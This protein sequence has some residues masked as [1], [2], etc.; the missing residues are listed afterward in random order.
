MEADQD[1]SAQT[2][3][4]LLA[5]HRAMSRLYLSLQLEESFDARQY[6]IDGNGAVGWWEFVRVWN[7][8]KIAVQ[9]SWLE[10]IYLT[11]E[12]PS[13]SVVSRMVTMVLVTVILLSSCCFIFSTIP[14]LQQEDENDPDG[15]P[16]ANAVLT[17]IEAVCVVIFTLEYLLRL[18]TAS[19]MRQELTDK[20]ILLNRICDDN[21]IEWQTSKKRLL[22]FII[23]PSNVVDL[24]SILP[25][26]LSL[27]GGSD[28]GGSMVV[29][30][31]VRMM[32]VTRAVKIGRYIE[33]LTIIKITMQKSARAMY[34]LAFLLFGGIV[35]F[36]SLMYFAESGTWDPET[37]TYQRQEGVVWDANVRA[38]IDVLGE[39]PYRS[40]PASFWWALVTATTVGYGDHYPT[41]PAGKFVGALCMFWS[42][43]VLALPVGIIGSNFTRVWEE[44]EKEKALEIEVKGKQQKIIEQSAKA[45][46]PLMYARQIQIEVWHCEQFSSTQ[47]KIVNNCFLGEMQ[48]DMQLKD[49]PEHC[50]VT[51][52]LQANSVKG[53]AQASGRVTV[54]C[55]WQPQELDE[56]DKKD[57]L[58]KDAPLRGTLE[59]KVVR[60]DGLMNLDWKA[61]GMTDPFARV[62]VFPTSPLPDPKGNF[63]LQPQVWDTRVV[64]DS[65]SPLWDEKKLF[66]F[67][68][69]K[70]GVDA[71][72]DV[73]TQ[74]V[75]ESSILLSRMENPNSVSGT[76][77]TV[78]G[79]GSDLQ[80]S[81]ENA[82]VLS[83]LALLPQIAAELTLLRKKVDSM[84]QAQRSLAPVSP[85]LGAPPVLPE[86]TITAKQS[87]GNSKMAGKYT[88]P[89]MDT[90][91]NIMPGVPRDEPEEIA[92]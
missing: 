22:N 80:G 61:G 18:A 24:L 66:S 38:F 2:D 68:W 52:T 15:E 56:R 44:F 23:S 53:S 11:L 55:S 46:D 70:E 48:L 3:I 69:T 12:D 30:R 60:A 10:R 84:E 81:A 34:V 90:F 86:L 5:F 13:S 9:L 28:S 36:G 82:N 78:E 41:T 43:C 91:T 87:N 63:H 20:D 29:L 74:E 27:F 72:L 75:K 85:P 49:V 88:D 31:L 19:A 77:T 17:S 16:Q 64:E 54:E 59:V 4:P 33:A 62:T 32:R 26:W 14:E 47:S 21:V 37:H 71:M 76:Q 51:E 35:I 42:L 40:I 67:L 25:F 7:D 79:Q 65:V 58:L 50:I 39:S 6:D 92:A 89:K 1:T 8:K 57:P 73:A 83:Q 45:L